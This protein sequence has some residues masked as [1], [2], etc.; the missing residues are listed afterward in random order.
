MQEKM[1]AED[2]LFEVRVGQWAILGPM[3]SG[4]VK[5]RDF[6][7]CTALRIAEVYPPNQEKLFCGYPH[8]STYQCVYL[9]GCALVPT[10]SLF[11][12]FDTEIEAR[13]FIAEDTVAQ[14][15]RR[16]E[17]ERDSHQATRKQLQIIRHALR[18]L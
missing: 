15:T 4:E 10:F 1:K 16:L 17:L 3:V 13:L 7:A 5:F 2:V 6:R 9:E 8:K 11:K 12:V 18:A 14:L